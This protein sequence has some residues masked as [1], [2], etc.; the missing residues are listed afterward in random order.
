[1]TFLYPYS[2]LAKGWG[3]HHRG[4]AKW[5]L[6][7][8]M[9]VPYTIVTSLIIIAMAN[10]VYDG[11]DAVRQ[12]LQPVEAAA[13][14]STLMHSDLG[15]MIL[16]LGFLAMTCGAISTHMVVCGFT[17]CEMLG[18]QYTRARFR[19]F[20]L[21]PVIGILGAGMKLPFWLPIL[22]SAICLTMLPIVYL[23]I[24]IMANNRKYIGD[25]V[26]SGFTRWVFNFL[27][28]VAI[29]V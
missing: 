14:F 8:S 18:L 26:G 2:I 24:M 7:S 17:V 19:L 12:G 15:R 13:A 16:D 28:L 21:T 6:F 20:S 10:T 5:D 3:K 1:M 9:L 11:K 4:L 23:S 29:T 25:A 27:L 22:A